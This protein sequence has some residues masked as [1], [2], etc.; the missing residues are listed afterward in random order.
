[1]IYF[2]FDL[3]KIQHLQIILYEDMVQ[4]VPDSPPPK[5][6]HISVKDL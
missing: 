4:K 3:K 5:K 6:N 2:Y 1:M